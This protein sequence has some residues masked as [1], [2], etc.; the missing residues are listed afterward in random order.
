MLIRTT[1]AAACLA[2]SVAILGACVPGSSSPTP[3]PVAKKPSPS[4]T[5]IRSISPTPFPLP[6]QVPEPSQ[7]PSLY[8]QIQQSEY[9]ALSVQTAAGASCSAVATLPNGQNAGGLRN[10]QTADGNGVITWWYPH[11]ATAEGN[12]THRVQCS[13]SGL[14]A[15]NYASF[16]VGA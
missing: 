8:L 16:L 3:T 11:P 2:I 6:S 12:G 15:S 13:K 5:A 1:R 9:G 10:P 14:S 4:P 7:A